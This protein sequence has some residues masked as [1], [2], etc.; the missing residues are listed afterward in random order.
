MKRQSI[1]LESIA[2]YDNLLNAA[3]KAARG[4]RFRK[5]VKE[6]FDNLDQQLAIMRA[7]VLTGQAPIGLYRNFRI[8]DPKKR[9]ISAASFPDRVL[10]HAIINCAGPVFEKS[11]VPSTFACRPGKGALAAVYRVQKNI[12]RYP[13]YVKIDIKDYFNQ[14]DHFV[15]NELLSNRFKG[16]EFLRLLS[17]IIDSYCSKP[18]KGLPIGSLTSQY[19]ANYYLDRIDRD[20]LGCQS[21]KGYLRYMDDIIWWCQNNSDAKKTLQFVKALVYEQRKLIIKPSHQINRSKHGVTFCGYRILPGLIRLT[22]RR[23]RRYQQRRIAW[24][25]AHMIGDV[26]EHELQRAYDSVHS[27]TIHA[28]AQA[29]RRQ[30]LKRF[31][32]I[33]L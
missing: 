19:F 31:P 8:Y 13:W 27:I 7:R 29:W 12:E 24:E 6:F 28:N 3:A 32:S 14:I 16:E 5:P 22:P 9:L 2:S 33:D 18:G 21:T 1:S 25:R 20:I 23:R 10:H 4:K 17:Q 30:N 26:N 15:L 11:M